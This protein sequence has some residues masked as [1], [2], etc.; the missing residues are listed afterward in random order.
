M[1][2]VFQNK[3]LWI[4]FSV[5]LIF[6]LLLVF[7][8]NKYKDNNIIYSSLKNEIT[9]NI[10]EKIIQ[11]DSD[12]DGLKD[13]E[14]ALWKT[15]PNNS[16]T[17]GDGVND[18]EEI[19]AERD[20]LVEGVGN[21]NNIIFTEQE[22][23]EN[24]QTTLTQTDVLAR[25]VFTGYMALKQNNLLGTQEQ[26][27]FIEKI[28]SNSLS[29]ELDTQYLTLNDLNIISTSNNESFQKYADE[30]KLIL[31]K[32]P[33]LRDDNI[34]LKEALDTNSLKK[35]EEIK[36]NIIFYEKLIDDLIKT[37]VPSALQNKHL[38]LI[39]SFK[40]IISNTEQMIQVFTDPIL[41]LVGA[42][43]YY[44]TS[45]ETLMISAEIGEFFKRNNIKF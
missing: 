33:E 15:D 31:S 19:L 4:I 20:P 37:E 13:W 26:K 44:N 14:E 18:K 24:F 21:L 12:N 38:N 27:D 23:L 28:T 34:I 22:N 42:K 30:L 9:E 41:A 7:F 5:V 10:A 11:K 17:D 35:L 25:E 8:F 45:L 29:F 32:F 6:L 40:K 36:S 43:Q 16:D 3:K 1:I 2:R 39:N